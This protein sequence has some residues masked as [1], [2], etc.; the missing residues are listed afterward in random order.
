MVDVITVQ[1]SVG[2]PQAAPPVAPEH[3]TTFRE[4]LS[5]LNPLQYLPVIG[6]IYRAIT[7]DQI[8]E[9]ARDIGSVVV[10]ALTGGPIGAAISAGVALAEKVTGI[11][12]DKIGQ[13]MLAKMGMTHQP[14]ASPDSAPIEVAGPDS[15]AAPAALPASSVRSG[16]VPDA[17]ASSASQPAPSASSPALPGLS[18]APAVALTQAWSPAQLAA[19][20]VSTGSD[21]SLKLAGLSGADVLNSLEISRIQVAQNAY[22]RAAGLAG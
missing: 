21:G 11:D 16:A 17:S 22:G 7:G 8:P 13:T 10:G 2:T 15:S 1:S 6:T 19:Y 12:F 20:G 18:V 14:A 9:M 3:H 4:V 5:M